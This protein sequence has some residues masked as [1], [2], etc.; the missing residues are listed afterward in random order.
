MPSA[1]IS[2]AVGPDVHQLGDEVRVRRAGGGEEG[3][4][5]RTGHLQR[6]L[7]AARTCRSGRPAAPPP[8][9]GRAGRCSRRAAR[10]ATWAR[11]WWAQG[12]WGRRR[13]CRAH[14]RPG[15]RARAVP[16]P[17]G[18][19]A[20]GGARERP[21]VLVAPA[22]LAHD[23]D[24]HRRVVFA[25]VGALQ[26][27]REEAKLQRRESIA[28]SPK[29]GSCG[30][31]RGRRCCRGPTGPRAASVLARGLAAA[32]P[33]HAN[34]VVERAAEED[35]VPAAHREAGHAHPVVMAVDGQ[36]LPEGV[37]GGVVQ[38][39][40]IEA[41]RVRV[42]AAPCATGGGRRGRPLRR[43][44]PSVIRRVQRLKPSWKAPPWYQPAVEVGSR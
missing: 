24:P 3:T 7:A 15:A 26:V 28:L 32:L 2:I 6:P 13:T 39:V 17:A 36:P 38:P 34:E 35:V 12:R 27:S 42:G 33:P 25:R 30:R 9:A 31:D 37:V 8:A 5:E 20:S 41:P 16:R 1:R 23:E 44:P 10:A 21:V 22:V 4:D 40:E 43:A 14:R 19:R 18:T 29:A 11:R